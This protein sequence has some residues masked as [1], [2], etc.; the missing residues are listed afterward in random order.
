MNKFVISMFLLLSCSGFAHAEWTGDKAEGM[1]S[2]VTIKN[3][4]VGQIDRSPYFC[5]SATKDSNSTISAC[6]IK[7]QSIWKESYDTLYNQVMYFYSTGQQVRVYYAPG[8]WTYK[9]FKDS[10]TSNVLVGLS[11]CES[12]TSCYGPERKKP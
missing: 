6:Q 4:H 1:V 3:I 7:T 9:P 11:T 8:A 12:D 10:L 2:N 5:F